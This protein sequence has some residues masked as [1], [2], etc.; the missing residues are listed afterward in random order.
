VL[1]AFCASGTDTS[2]ELLCIS[3]F[4][5]LHFACAYIA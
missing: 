2:G 3:D 5:E 1:S 4:H